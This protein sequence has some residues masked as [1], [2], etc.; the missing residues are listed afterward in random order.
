MRE[1][2][3]LGLRGTCLSVGR[4]LDIWLLRAITGQSCCQELKIFIR[5]NTRVSSVHVFYVLQSYWSPRPVSFRLRLKKSTHD[6]VSYLSYSEGTTALC[7]I[8]SHL[9][10]SCRRTSRPS[11]TLNP[12][13]S[14]S[15]CDHKSSSTS[16]TFVRSREYV[17]ND[18]H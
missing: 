16:S 7:F 5:S 4:G 13:S 9:L 3:W 14:R 17:M 11:R 12:P 6:I 8:S 1:G 2:W 10:G 15:R 18:E